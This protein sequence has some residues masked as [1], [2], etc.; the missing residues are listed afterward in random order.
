MENISRAAALFAGCALF[1][2]LSLAQFGAGGGT[3]N[4]EAADAQRDN[5]ARTDGRINATSMPGFQ[6]LWKVKTSN[7]ATSSYALSSPV[8]VDGYIGYRGFRSYA[9]V[10]GASNNAIALDSDVGRVEWTQ[11]FGAAQGGSGICGSGTT[12]GVTR[13]T[14]LAPAAANAAAGGRG[15]GGRGGQ[16]AASGVG[17][18]GAGAITIGQGRG[19][20]FGGGG[21]GAPGG[22]GRGG[23]GG[24]GGPGGRGGSG[25]RG[26]GG[27]GG[28][29]GGG[30]G[31]PNALWA[32]SAD[33][34]L[35]ALYISNGQDA[36]PAVRFLPAGAHATGLMLVN[37]VIYA[38]TSGNCGGAPNG[39]WAIDTSAT[40][41]TVMHWSTNGGGIAGTVGP[42]LGTEG[43]VYAATQDGD[44]SPTAFSDS[45]VALDSKTFTMKDWFT[46]GKSEFSSSPVVFTHTQGDKSE[47]L[48]AVANKDGKL[49][50]L[51]GADLGG[52]DHK[53]PLSSIQFANSGADVGALASWEDAQGTR[54]VLV[55]ETGALGST[56]FPVTNG[57]V[58]GGSVEAF[59][60]V[61]QGGK[62]TLQPG[63]VSRDITAP[64]APIVINGYVFTASSGSNP[65]LYAIDGSNGKDL[66]NSATTITGTS[67]HNSSLSGSQGQIY[68]STSDSTIWTFGIP[69][70]PPGLAAKQG[71]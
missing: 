60:V 71:Q 51:D 10:G 19:G 66:F 41:P 26:P 2:G 65:V 8:M 25:G 45:V 36:K 22:S 59:K 30:R 47:D 24:P 6:F 35:H 14:P 62:P 13:P 49:Y 55:G 27:G 5:W 12:A 69:L 58:S 20:G 53:T 34:M 44:Y 37:N 32:V 31:G 15:G 67:L 29:G 54:W 4:T 40:S 33:G 56:R 52:A 48:V 39:I 17:E 46:P 50:L 16:R 57:G 63:W 43:V 68:L 70:V 11:N 38:A 23:P 64:L 7:N 61:D 28:F 1:A 42:A 9:F 21:F 18:P 3:W